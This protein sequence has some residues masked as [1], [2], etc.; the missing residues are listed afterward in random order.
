MV[1]LRERESQLGEDLTNG[2]Y[3]RGVDSSKSVPLFNCIN[4]LSTSLLCISAELSTCIPSGL[5]GIPYPPGLPGPLLP[6]PPGPPLTIGLCGF[7]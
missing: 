7:W 1:L 2:R 6:N 5:L 3:I 4:V